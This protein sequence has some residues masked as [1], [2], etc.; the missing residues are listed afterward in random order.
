LKPDGTYSLARDGQLQRPLTG[1]NLNREMSDLHS[2]INSSKNHWG[3]ELKGL[4]ENLSNGGFLVQVLGYVGAVFTDGGTLPLVPVGEGMETTG[5][6][7]SVVGNVTQ[8]KYKDEVV[9]TGT[10]IIFGAGGKKLENLEQAGKLTTVQKTLL[11]AQLTGA[12][13]LVDKALD[14]QKDND[15]TQTDSNSKIGDLPIPPPI[16]P[17]MQ[18]DNILH[19]DLFN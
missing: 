5:T 1:E 9:A 15:G 13:K 3:E 17:I 16:D 6:G 14:N 2:R 4:G 18:R 12:S 7:L 19:D 8:G 10:T 11:G